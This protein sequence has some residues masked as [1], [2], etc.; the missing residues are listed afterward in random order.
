MNH[1]DINSID[2]S[3]ISAKFIMTVIDGNTEEH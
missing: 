2:Q 3:E 1:D